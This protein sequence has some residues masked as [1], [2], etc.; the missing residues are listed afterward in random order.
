MDLK[1]FIEINSIEYVPAFLYY[2]NETNMHKIK[3]DITDE[4][5]NKDKLKIN[6]K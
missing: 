6:F 5:F 4:K 3:F 1:N 2:S